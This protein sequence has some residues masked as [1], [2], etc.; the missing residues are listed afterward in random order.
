MRMKAV[1]LAAALIVPAVIGVPPAAAQTS[2]SV[3]DGV[4]TAAQAAR[5]ADAFGQHCASCH[6]AGLEGTGEAPGLTGAQFLSD[7]SGLTMG[8]LFDRTRTSMPQ[9]APNSLSR[10]MYADILAFVLKVNGFPAGQKE[11]DHRSAYLQAIAFLATNP[12]PAASPA[13]A[14]AAAPPPAPATGAAPA[15]G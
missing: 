10:E 5:G 1:F 8:D 7:F 13:P 2:T 9:D 4:Y 6:G 15:G 11:L 12:H 3:W 14:P